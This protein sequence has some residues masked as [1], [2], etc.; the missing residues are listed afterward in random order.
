VTSAPLVLLVRHCE[1]TGQGPEAALTARGREQAERLAEAMAA[2][3]LT[4]LAASPFRRAR[5]TLAPLARRTGLPPTIDPRLA[6]WTTPFVPAADWPA[7]MAPL[8]RGETAPPAGFE[9]LAAARARG[10]AA[11]QDALAAGGGT[12]VLVTHG[13]LLALVVAALRHADPF[14]VFVTIQNPHVFAVEAGVPEP[15]VR[16]LALAG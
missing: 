9:P 14:A 16:D 11:L 15:A 10:L 6:E 13:K 7:G 4:A 8:L 1:S 2:H 3:P 12:R 5:D